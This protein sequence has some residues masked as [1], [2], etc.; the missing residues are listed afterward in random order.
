MTRPSTARRRA[1][2][3]AK[4]L[5][6]RDPAPLLPRMAARRLVHT[7]TRRRALWFAIAVVALLVLPAVLGAVA[8]ANAR[9]G[10]SGSSTIDALGWMN[11]H[12]TSGVPLSDYV[13]ATGGESVLHPGKTAVALLLGV[14]FTG[15]MVLVTSAI[16]IIGYAL[17]FAWLD[18]F[19]HALTGVAHSLTGAIATPLMFAA[20]AA[21]GAVFVGWFIVRGYH[22]KAI[23]QVA[24]M[25]GVAVVGA[26]FLADPLADVLSSDG[27]LAQGRNV[28]ISIAAGVNGDDRPDPSGLIGALSADLADNFARKPVQVWNFGHVVDDSLSCRNAWSMSVRSGDDS[29]V[30]ANMRAC[31]D[32]NARYRAEHPSLGQAGTGFVLL[33]SALVLLAFAAYLAGKVMRTALDSIFHA[34]LAIFGFAAGGYIYGPTQTFLVRNIVDSVVAAGRM[35]AYTV[36][37]GVY[38]LFL[39]NVFEQAEGRI[40]AVLVIGAVVEVVAITQLRLLSA[41]L[42]AGNEWLANRMGL[43]LQAAGSKPGGGQALGM[44]SAGAGGHAHGVGALAALGAISTVSGSPAIGHLFGRK[45]PL[46]PGSMEAWD[47]LLNQHGVWGMPWFAGPRGAYPRSFLGQMQFAHHARRGVAGYGRVNTMRGGGG[48][49]VS[50]ME[51]GADL[52]DLR[53]GLVGAEFDDEA[54]MMHLEQSFGLVEENARDIVLSNKHLGRVVAATRR[55]DSQMYQVAKGEPGANVQETAADIVALQASAFRLRRSLPGAITLDEPHLRHVESYMRAP[56]KP[57]IENLQQVIS[58]APG[59][60]NPLAHIDQGDAERMLEWIKI[61]HAADIKTAADN[62]IANPLDQQLV[63]DM[64][65]AVSAATNTHNWITGDSTDDRTHLAPSRRS[66]DPLPHWGSRLHAVATLLQ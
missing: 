34:L 62:L 1:R 17:S 10:A 56:K 57:W 29:A 48:A 4:E 45:D 18:M 32:D 28:G 42:S 25:I 3:E 52:R 12:D 53:S 65:N 33:V 26:V 44:G 7:R 15:Y 13:F 40:L 2:P 47:L 60:H 59:T 23:A 24:T 66:L 63:A 20:A 46:S 31:G 61:T 9:T 64:R 21:I 30:K 51:V 37:L 41:S 50:M 11:I 38:V 22:A 27:L 43:A 19:G 54:V 16:W 14:E 39:G 55:V 36:F 49:I 35:A 5:W 58:G 8:T 6:F